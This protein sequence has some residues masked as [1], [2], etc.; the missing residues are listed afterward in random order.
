[1]SEPIEQRD[2]AD[3]HI[4]IVDLEPEDFTEDGTLRAIPVGVFDDETVE[5]GVM[6]CITTDATRHAINTDPATGEYLPRRA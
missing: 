5:Y 4:R 6:P 3:V 2:H 1:M